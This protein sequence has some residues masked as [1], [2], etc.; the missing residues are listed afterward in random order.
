MTW[1]GRARQDQTRLDE[2]WLGKR[3][4]PTGRTDTEA[5]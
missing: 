2:T 4:H 3:I 1:L 5:R